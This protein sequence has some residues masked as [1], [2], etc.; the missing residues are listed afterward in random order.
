MRATLRHY[1]DYVSVGNAVP[2]E[3]CVITTRCSQ[4]ALPFLID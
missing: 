3:G 2:K 4:T 1:D